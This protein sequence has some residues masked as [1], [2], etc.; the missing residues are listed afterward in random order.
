MADHSHQVGFFVGQVLEGTTRQHGSKTALIAKEGEMSFAALN[1]STTRIAAHMQ[2]E[3]VKQG[4]RVGLLLPNSL[5]FAI[6]YYATQRM[7][8]VTTILDARF[9]GKELEG[10]LRDSDLSLLITH[11][12]LMPEVAKSLQG[13][14]LPLWVV[15][16]EGDNSFQ[17]R[18]FSPPSAEFVA[19]RLEPDQDAVILY[20]S[21]TTGEPKG[22]VLTHINLAQ[23]PL[24]TTEVWVTTADS[25]WGCILPMSHISGPI[26]CNEII[27]KG[28]TMVIFDQINPI[29]I[30][31]GLAK[32][33]VT[34]IHGVPPIFGLLLGVRN[35]KDYDTSN[36]RVAAMMGMTV[37]LSLMQAFKAALPHIK[38]I[39]GYGLTETSPL[40]TATPL[41]DADAKLASIGRAVP[42]IEVKIVDEKGQQ[43]E[44]GEIITRGPHLMKGYFRRPEATAERIRNGWLHTGDVAR[45]EADGYYYHL[46]RKDDMIITGGMNVYPAE[47]ENLLSTHPKVLEAVVFPIPD[48]DRGKAIAAAVVPRPETEVMD[49]ELLTFLRSNLASFKVPQ[50]VVIRESLPRTSTGK[51]KREDLG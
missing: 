9:K 36:L 19:P 45:R 28:S 24:H 11:A 6:S 20:T 23:F 25:V 16:G 37:P 34:F 15:D 5:A 40:I 42:G 7:G 38:V 27:D 29:T 32:Y 50:R 18:L 26:Y 41:R 43:R 8:A 48:P 2:N 1:E 14:K 44:E 35:L 51:V 47:V 17:K 13:M 49:R 31:E 21:G 30:L 22:V 39:Q 33:K 10:V 12:S 4:D 46:G 3:G